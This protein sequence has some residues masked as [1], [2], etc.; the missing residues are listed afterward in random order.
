MSPEVVRRQ[1]FVDRNLSTEIVDTVNVIK[2]K[3]SFLAS[4]FRLLGINNKRG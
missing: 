3:L 1:K 2:T 4:K